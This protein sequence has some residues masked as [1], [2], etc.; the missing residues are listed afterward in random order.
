MVRACSN[1]CLITYGSSGVNITHAMCLE[2]GDLRVDECYTL[3][4]R[5]FKYTLIHVRTRIVRSTVT[6]MM[7]KLGNAYGIR[8]ATIFGYDAVS[9]G[10]EVDEHPGMRLIEDHCRR[11]SSCL[12]C[13]T[14]IGNIRQHSRG[15]L[16]YCLPGV[17]LEQMTRLQLMNHVKQ[18]SANMEE[19]K[20][21]IAGMETA[22]LETEQLRNL[23][24]RQQRRIGVYERMFSRRGREDELLPP[25]P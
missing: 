22:V 24:E 7:L 18:L 8:A 6:S 4:Q 15:L 25:S 3:T 20:A 19:Y 14:E 11:E 9:V 12:E 17:A 10:Q 2:Q 5:D 23:V 16:F 21:T 13:W 1:R